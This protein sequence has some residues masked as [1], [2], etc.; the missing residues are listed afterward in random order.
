[1]SAFT[2]RVLVSG[3]AGIV[4]HTNRKQAV[5]LFPKFKKP[6]HVPAV[7]FFEKNLGGQECVHV[8]ASP[9]PETDPKVCYFSTMGYE[10]VIVPTRFPTKEEIPPMRLGEKWLTNLSDVK[11]K[12][13]LRDE[14]ASDL[15][16]IACRLWI[17]YHRGFACDLIGEDSSK[18]RCLKYQVGKRSP[19]PLAGGV[20]F[21]VPMKGPD[22]ELRLTG[23]GKDSL[24]PPKSVTLRPATGSN[25]IDLIVTNV[26]CKENALRRLLTLLVGPT[27]YEDRH[28]RVFYDLLGSFSG[29]KYLPKATAGDLSSVF[30]QENRSKSGFWLETEDERGGIDHWRPCAE[31]LAGPPL[32][33]KALF[34]R[35]SF[36]IE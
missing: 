12:F 34:S 36:E 20:I 25:S 7:G 23:L 28:F 35:A 27:L 32:C 30:A 13:L 18:Q 2:L 9:S 15:R 8:G 16:E 24:A 19:Q 1:M 17:Q 31:Q 14:P 11:S 22:F 10:I 29:K 33:T 4:P 6:E 21:E 26:P 3:L 5:V